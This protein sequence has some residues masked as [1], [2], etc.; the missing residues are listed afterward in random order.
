[1]AL[2]NYEILKNVGELAKD[3]G[4]AIKPSGDGGSTITIPEWIN[5][6]TKFLTNI[7]TDLIDDDED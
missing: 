7:G 2:E 6:G 4:E 3:I 5:I 1:M